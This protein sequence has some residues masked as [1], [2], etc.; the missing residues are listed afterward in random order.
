[1]LEDS[2][3]FVKQG[4][5]LALGLV[6]QQ[7]SEAHFPKVKE[8]RDKIL[9]ITNDRHQST[10]TKM[11]AILAL[12]IMDVGG[13]NA[14]VSMVSR[15]GFLIDTSVVGVAVWLQYW[16]WFPLLHFLSLAVTPTALISLTGEMKIPTGFQPVCDAPPSW[17]AYIPAME[18]KKENKVEKMTKMELSVSAKAKAKAN[19]K[20]KQEN[21]D[22]EMTPTPMSPSPV[23]VDSASTGDVKPE[24]VSDA[25]VKVEETVHSLQVAE[26]TS[27]V[28]TNPAR[29]TP[30]QAKFVSMPPASRYRP[31]QDLQAINSGIVVLKDVDGSATEDSSLR[32]VQA[33]TP[34]DDEPRAPEAFEWIVGEY[35]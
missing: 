23:V 12:G 8:L 17:F 33:P 19:A 30:S 1:M 32:V 18:E 29:V 4:A 9:K 24:N 25:I 16:F 21:G 13:R 7:E 35:L 26:V 5:L 2:I 22:V 11:G 34:F 3:D 15:S 27:F 10:M 14:V 31:V 28:L 6:L 20:A